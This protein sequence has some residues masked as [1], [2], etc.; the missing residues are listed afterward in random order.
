MA[1]LLQLSCGWLLAASVCHA[2]AAPSNGTGGAIPPLS[3]EAG[4]WLICCASYTGADAAELARQCALIIRTRDNLPAYVINYGEQ[5]RKKREAEI[6]QELKLNPDARMPRRGA[7]I[8]DQCAVVIG[9]YQTIDAARASLDKVKKLNA[10]ELKV[11]EG[12]VNSDVVSLY[13][14]V[15]GKGV[16][17]RREMVN[18]FT[19]SFVTRNPTIPNNLPPP[20]KF[21]PFIKKLN[22]E[23]SYSLLRT[24]KKWTLLVKEYRG[25]TMVQSTPGGANQAGGFLEKIGFSK[26]SDTLNACALQARETARVLRRLEFDAYVLHTKTTSMVTIGSFDREDDPKMQ[27]VVAHLSKLNLG[28]LDLAAK[29]VPM[30]IPRFDR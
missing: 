14:P 17:I 19:R 7:K 13:V 27:Q 28:P 24:N 15:P 22:A 16:E 8:P 5:E 18:P 29:P 30:E 10:P 1:R 12:K 26:N 2:L 3:P 6:E 23:E 20:P 25:A 11:A 21:D 9:G 4:N